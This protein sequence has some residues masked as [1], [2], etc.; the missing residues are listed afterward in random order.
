VSALSDKKTD[1][2]DEN[3]DRLWK[4]RTVFKRLSKSCAKYGG[5][6]EHLAVEITAHF[7]VTVYSNSMSL[8]DADGLE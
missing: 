6:P 2:I 3:C 1:G 4:M 5:S 7:K 8:R